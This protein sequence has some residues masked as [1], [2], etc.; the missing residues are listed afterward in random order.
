[1]FIYLL[2]IIHRK[3]IYYRF[4]NMITKCKVPVQWTMLVFSSNEKR[5][6]ALNST[7]FL[8]RVLP[9]NYCVHRFRWF[10]L[11]SSAGGCRL[12]SLYNCT[13]MFYYLSMFRRSFILQNSYTTSSRLVVGRFLI[14]YE[15]HR[16][17]LIP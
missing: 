4:I 1:M 15:H 6:K 5:W 10:F 8:F 17:K 11:Y 7:F 2:F 16:W 9:H 12:V 3:I 14:F 13:L